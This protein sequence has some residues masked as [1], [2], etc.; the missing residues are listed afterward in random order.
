M[1]WHN[2]DP[3][4]LLL[5]EGK[6]EEFNLRRAQGEAC[7]LT[8]SDFRNLDLRGLNADG[9][10]LS[11]GYFRQADLRG[12]DF[13]RARLEGA[14]I[15]HASISGVYFPRELSASEIL[16]SWEHGARMRYGR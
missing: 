10:D 16:M 13:S 5:R 14:S 8:G 15:N 11:D 12:I 6:V 4:Y 7:Q 9:L 1:K 2:N 3:M